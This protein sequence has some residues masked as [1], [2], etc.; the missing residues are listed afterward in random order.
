[1]RSTEARDPWDEVEEEARARAGPGPRAQ[2]QGPGLP[3]LFQC[4]TQA[5]AGLGAR[6]IGPGVP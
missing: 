1:M 6:M 4:N 5:Q 3:G 2:T